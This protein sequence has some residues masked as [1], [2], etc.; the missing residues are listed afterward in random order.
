MRNPVVEDLILR[1]IRS[2]FLARSDAPSLYRICGVGPYPFSRSDEVLSPDDRV[3]VLK[4][5]GVMCAATMSDNI[6]DYA[7]IWEC[8]E[9]PVIS[10][11]VCRN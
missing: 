6:V 11:L 7:E 2:R 5:G 3:R 10:L 9:L 1:N 8:D 4:G